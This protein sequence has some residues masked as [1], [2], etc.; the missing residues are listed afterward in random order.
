MYYLLEILVWFPIFLGISYVVE[1]TIISRNLGPFSSLFNG[2]A[3]IGVMVHELSHFT[4]CLLVGIRP[5]GISVKLRDQTGQVNP[6]GKVRVEP[7]GETFLQAALI[8]L[9]PIFISTWLF[10]YSLE[11]AFSETFDPL[12]RIL[13]G[14]FCLTL[15]LGAVPST[16]DFHIISYWFKED[17][18]YSIYQLLLIFVS[19]VTTLMILMFYHI[20]ILDIFY[21]F[22]VGIM[23]AVFKYS[24]MGF[25][26]L[27]HS[28]HNHHER[29]P[30]RSNFKRFTRKRFKPTKPYKLGREEA[31]W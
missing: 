18:K 27:I 23:Y 8:S 31:H 12:L 22:L 14:F 15:F 24:F 4:M 19:G 26:K 3:Y 20:I 25:N 28:S 30:S 9:A 13:A 6:H 21:F 17:P 5:K 1:K 11:I 16:T 29:H 2:L 7:H 10:F